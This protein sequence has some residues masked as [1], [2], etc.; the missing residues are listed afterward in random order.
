MEEVVIYLNHSCFTSKKDNKTYY[1]VEYV[2]CDTHLTSRE[3]LTQDQYEK[4]Q[5]MK[6]TF[7]Q[8]VI[9]KYKMGFN[10]KLVFDSFEK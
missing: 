5:A 1:V 4:I 6:L 8:Q 9:V 2:S 3:F 10:K 7:L